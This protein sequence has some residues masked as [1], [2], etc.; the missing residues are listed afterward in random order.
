MKKLKLHG[1][2]ARYFYLAFEGGYNRANTLE[3][4]IYCLRISGNVRSAREYLGRYEESDLLTPNL[5]NLIAMDSFNAG[6]FDK[7]GLFLRKALAAKSD[8]LFYKSLEESLR[9][10]AVVNTEKRR[11]GFH[12]N[13]VF[14]YHIMK[15]IFD[16]LKN[17]FYCLMTA[18]LL[19]LREFEPDVVFVANSQAN[20]I[21][22][23]L[24]NACFI[25]T[26]HGLISKNFVFNAA[27]GCDYVMVPGPDQKREFVE[28][29]GFSPDKIWVTGYSQMDP[30][31][32]NETED[33][34]FDIDPSKP[35]LLYAPTFSPG[36]S[37]IPL[38]DSLLRTNPDGLDDMNVIM[39]LHPLAP[40]FYPRE[41]RSLKHLTHEK[42]NM[43]FAE[44]SSQNIVNY[45]AVA[46][47]LLSDLSSVVFQFLAL[48][49]PIVTVNHPNRR[50]CQQYDPDGLEW[51]WRDMGDEVEDMA[52]LL[53]A[54]R[55]AA[56]NPEEKKEIRGKY[57]S[58]L[59][60][61]IV[62]GRTGDRVR[63]H[64]MEHFEKVGQEASR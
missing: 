52:E 3:N 42:E 48:D 5:A 33:P 32:R 47:V 9:A 24:P 26:R 13:Q 61:D 10:A 8:D 34:G 14:H 11:V 56:A 7:A 16:S 64:L 18:D 58:L 29:G 20:P 60:G 50:T 17:D 12:L 62:D 1:E 45:L 53:P 38:V 6:D 19:T 15:P 44:A 25:Y 55:H 49:R 41:W 22:E 4:L 37:S 35:T 27:R 23:V 36:L 54:I 30:L 63:S 28:R 59:F 43:F 39:K 40:E 57:R 21:R 51:R 46:D 2:A 31:F